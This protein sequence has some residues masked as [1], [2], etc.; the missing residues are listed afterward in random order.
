MSERPSA[1]FPEACSGDI[2]AAVPRIRA[3]AVVTESGRVLWIDPG[4]VAHLG[5]TEVEHL[6]L[7]VRR[8]L[9]IRGFEITVDDASF[10]RILERFRNLF[11]IR[12]GFR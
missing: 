1:S 12:Q 3:G 9:D 4:V 6:Y 5:Q 2:Y 11:R 10:V 7:I 8:D